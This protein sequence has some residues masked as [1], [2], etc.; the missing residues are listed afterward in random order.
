[1]NFFTYS[2]PLCSTIKGF[3]FLQGPLGA[4]RVLITIL[5]SPF[6]TQT[7]LSCYQCHHQHHKLLEG[8]GAQWGGPELEATWPG[9]KVCP[10]Y[11]NQA[12]LPFR[13]SVSFYVKLEA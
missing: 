13:G 1:M 3:L 8:T 6:F 11:L 10:Q 2:L 4:L 7:R 9:V 5:F 12:S